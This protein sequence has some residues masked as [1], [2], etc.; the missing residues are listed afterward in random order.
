MEAVLN[1]EG[2][3][4]GVLMGFGTKSTKGDGVT[5]TKARVEIRMTETDL[6]EAVSKEFAASVFSFCVEDEQ[7][8]LIWTTEPFTP[9]GTY[10]SHTVQI[11]GGKKLEVQPKIVKIKPVEGEK[12]IDLELELPFPCSDEAM[13]G[14]LHRTVGS[15]VTV[16][17][18]VRQMEMPLGTVVTSGK[19]GNP[20]HAPAAATEA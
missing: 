11:A 14:K 3:H 10:P 8:G 12:S 13:A 19:F 20:K 15:Q 16:S 17:L 9:H 2:K 4:K 5:V 1:F 18:D 6:G 7:Q